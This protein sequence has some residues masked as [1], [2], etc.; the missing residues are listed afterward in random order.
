MLWIIIISQRVCP[1]QQAWSHE[2]WCGIT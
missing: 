2:L 1:E